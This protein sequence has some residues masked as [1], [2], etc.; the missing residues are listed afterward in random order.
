MD[1]LSLSRG[2]LSAFAQKFG[3]TAFPTTRKALIAEVKAAYAQNPVWCQTFKDAAPLSGGV[4][5]TLS[6]VRRCHLIENAASRQELFENRSKLLTDQVIL[7]WG[8][9]GLLSGKGSK[10]SEYAWNNEKINVE[11][12]GAPPESRTEN[13][14]ENKGSLS[15][16][17][18][19]VEAE[20][21]G[22]MGSRTQGTSTCVVHV[23]ASHVR[24][25]A[26]AAPRVLSSNSGYSS[27]CPAFQL[28]SGEV[29]EVVEKEEHLRCA[30]LARTACD[31]VAFDCDGSA[32]ELSQVYLAFPNS[33][34]LL[35]D[36]VKIGKSAV[37][38]SLKSLFAS[39]AKFIVHDVY[40]HASVL[41]QCG[42]AIHAGSATS[43]RFVDIQLAGE[44]LTGKFQ[45]SFDVT[46]QHFLG[47]SLE[48]R[49]GA[50][51]GV[52]RL[53]EARP[54]IEAALGAS[55]LEK[56]MT[57]TARVAHRAAHKPG[58]RRVGLNI[59][60]AYALASPELLEVFEPQA[61]QEQRALVTSN[62]VE[63]LLSL[64][65]VDIAVD[66]SAHGTEGLRDIVLDK[67]RRP[68]A[69]INGK[70]VFLGAEDREV[71]VVDLE[72][73]LVR[74]GDEFGHDN[75][76]GLERQLH[77][78]SAIRNRAGKVIGLTMRVGRH[79]DGNADMVIDILRS[80]A[81]PS[82]LFLGEPGS[83]KTTIIR[84]ATRLLAQK[85]NVLIVD[86]SNEI[87]GS[88][89]IPHECVGEAR[90]MQV[91]SLE[92]QNRVMVEGVQNHTPEVMVVDEIGRS[93]E[94][95]AARTCKQRGVRM[96]ASAHGDLRGLVK[97]KALHGLIGGLEQ[98]ILGDEQARQDAKRRQKLMGGT[99]FG[100]DKLKTQRAGAPVF[101]M[102]V[103]LRRGALNEWRFVMDVSK[104]VDLIL[105]GSAYEA[106]LRTRD[107]ETGEWSLDVALF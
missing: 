50:A 8:Q 12:A 28:S 107:P 85:S 61:L 41:V 26:A 68:L 34:A 23:P 79:I 45:M 73:T 22:L 15:G 32:D 3:K 80:T 52:A 14:S 81:A 11:L 20:P 1:G 21:A 48:S 65:P 60:K 87:A 43:T 70:R 5:P 30:L 83:G 33:N 67:G 72:E 98:V 59:N 57:A 77:R 96:I 4:I 90:R 91:R 92:E 89:D 86:T 54:H 101:D 62:A 37:F 106:Q 49:R 7:H 29:V 78:V 88:G 103:E 82:I 97:N 39:S 24:S 46:L 10:G 71:S 76:A 69:W 58:K 55:K 56:L 6:S 47:R 51:W 40:Q 38:S 105:D 84:E 9:V 75:R 95:D 104:A 63:P 42:A 44:L 18:G 13:E 53:L 102:I 35:V 17:G 16:T 2:M 100:I 31:W 36:C 27:S 94:V 99:R 25:A 66:I 19:A 93:A 74:L 64:L